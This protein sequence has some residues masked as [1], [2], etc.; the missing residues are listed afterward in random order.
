MTVADMI[1]KARVV[2]EVVL[3]HVHNWDKIDVEKL[4]PQML[5]WMVKDEQEFRARKVLGIGRQ[6]IFDQ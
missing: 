3:E 1:E 4:Q 2:E 5:L 6:P